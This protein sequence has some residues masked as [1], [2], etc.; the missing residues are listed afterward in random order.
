MTDTTVIASPTL[1]DTTVDEY[2]TLDQID[3]IAEALGLLL[4]DIRRIN[5]DEPPERM[6]PTQH[7]VQDIRQAVYA[8]AARLTQSPED[9]REVDEAAREAK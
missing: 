2:E 6:I 1:R 5:P 4:A 9:H 8:L 7:R 3:G